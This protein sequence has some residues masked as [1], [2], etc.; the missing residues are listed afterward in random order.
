VPQAE[1][2]TTIAATVEAALEPHRPALR[3]LVARAVDVTLER[4]LAELVAAELELRRNGHA[5]LEEVDGLAPLELEPPATSTKRCRTCREEKPLDAFPPDAKG[6]DGRRHVCRVCRQ[7][8]V[9]ERRAELSRARAGDVGEEPAPAGNR[10]GS[11]QVGNRL[12]GARERDAIEQRRAMLAEL[13]AN[14]VERELRDG[15]EFVVL[16]LPDFGEAPAPAPARVLPHVSRRGV[17]VA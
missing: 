3:E 14:G 4:M 17:A 16:R 2:E 7:R 8:R 12:V 15:R 11:R 10:S 9:R 13:R 5:A 1:L 6:R